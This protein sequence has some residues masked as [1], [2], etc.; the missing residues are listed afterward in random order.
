MSRA[1]STPLRCDPIEV[2]VAPPSWP[3]WLTRAAFVLA[4]ALVFARANSLRNDAGQL[5]TALLD[6][7][8]RNPIIGKFDTVIAADVLYE[9]RNAIALRDLLP[10]VLEREGRFI[11]AD[12]GRRFLQQFQSLMRE[13]GWN[14]VQAATLVESQ[15]TSKAEVASTIRIIEF[16]K[17]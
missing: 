2:A 9:Q 3:A 11:L 15:M 5:E 17:T 8:D 14:D 4:T 12:P 7:R 1:K 10:R 6:W 16:K 13:T